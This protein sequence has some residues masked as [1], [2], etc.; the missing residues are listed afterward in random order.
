[1]KG[2]RDMYKDLMKC[3]RKLLNEYVQDVLGEDDVSWDCKE[4]LVSDLISFGHG[5]EC[6]EYVNG[7]G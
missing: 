2:V 4:D 1:M 5:E 3:T 6:L 7:G